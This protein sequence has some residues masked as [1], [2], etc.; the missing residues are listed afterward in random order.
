MKTYGGGGIAPLFLTP[1]VSGQLQSP[2]ALSQEKEPTVPI[3]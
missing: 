3:G 1:E 2:A